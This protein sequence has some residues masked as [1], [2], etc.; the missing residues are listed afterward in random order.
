MPYIVRRVI[1]LV[2]VLLAMTFIVFCLESLVPT[3]PARAMAG[4]SAPISTVEMVRQQLGLD[5]P[6]PTRY[7]RFLL[8]LIQGDLGMSVRTRQP[9]LN[10]IMR[11]LPASLELCAFAL[12]GGALLAL[13]LAMLQ[14]WFPNAASL[15]FAITAA[16]SAPIFLTGLLS[17]YLFWFVLGW[18][19]GSGRL[20]GRSFAGPTGF[21][22]LDGLLA[23]R[24]DIVVDAIAH[25]VLPGLTLALPIAVAIGRSLAGA[26]HDVMRQPYIRTARGKGLAEGRVVLC[27]GLRNAASAPLAMA[28][29]QVGLLFGNLLIVEQTFA[30]PGIG[31]YMVQAFASS[32]LPAIL[33]ASLVLGAIYLAIGIVIEIAQS[34]ADPRIT[35]RA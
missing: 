10:D 26:L 2:I 14:G 5:Q 23:G 18:L 33:G 25:L 7:G 30:W 8:R 6:L 29:L 20:T 4:V 22:V 35:L 21:N 1:G 28:G 11:Y 17:A 34:L 32:D 3:D 24:A 16:G 12:L 31:L 13:C 19:P 15:R 27:H 9:V